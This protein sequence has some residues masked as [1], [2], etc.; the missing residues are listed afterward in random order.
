MFNIGKRD[1]FIPQSH[2]WPFRKHGVVACLEAKHTN[3]QVVDSRGRV[4]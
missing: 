1:F 2:N 3:C 4:F